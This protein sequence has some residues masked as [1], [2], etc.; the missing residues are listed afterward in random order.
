MAEELGLGFEGAIRVEM[1][2]GRA[3]PAARSKA[4]LALICCLLSFFT[5]A[6]LSTFLMVSQP[7][8]P[9]RD[10]MPRVSMLAPA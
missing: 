2:E 9:G 10:C 5:V 6:G 8:A 7:R 1:P 3:R 4:C